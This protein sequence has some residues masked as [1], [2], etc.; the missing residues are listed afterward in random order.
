[1]SK[2]FFHVRQPNLLI[3]CLYLLFASTVVTKSINCF[4][5]E[6]TKW[7]KQI[8]GANKHETPDN[9]TATTIHDGDDNNS[10]ASTDFLPKISDDESNAGANKYSTSAN[11]VTSMDD[12]E[13]GKY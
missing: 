7:S 12:I 9:G 11:D 5:L 8:A 10:N 1:M 4:V 13:I 2:Y 3:Y 6:N